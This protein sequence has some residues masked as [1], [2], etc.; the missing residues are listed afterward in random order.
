MTGRKRK[1]EVSAPPSLRIQRCG[2]CFFH[3]PLGAKPLLSDTSASKSEIVRLTECSNYKLPELNK[4][5][6]R[7]SIRDWRSSASRGCGICGAILRYLEE[8]LR[9]R[10]E[11]QEKLNW[12]YIASSIGYGCYNLELYLNGRPE[13]SQTSSSSFEVIALPDLL[14]LSNGVYRASHYMYVLT[15]CRP[16]SPPLCSRAL[17]PF[18]AHSISDSL[19]S[20]AKLDCE[21]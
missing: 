12:G 21:L 18:W 5:V 10:L 4:S 1:R 6:G 13:Q 2:Q 15:R 19:Q 14:G 16:E 11:D 7:S 20:F 9:I 17:V 3:L 8:Q